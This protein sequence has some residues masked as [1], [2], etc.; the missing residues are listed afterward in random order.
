[1]KLFILRVPLKVNECIVI[2]IIFCCCISNSDCGCSISG[3]SFPFFVVEVVSVELGN[4]FYE[5][6]SFDF[7]D[8]LAEEESNVLA[9]EEQEFYVDFDVRINFCFDCCVFFWFGY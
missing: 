1:M 3:G 5:N 4:T 8:S 7:S 6:N 2:Y 9:V